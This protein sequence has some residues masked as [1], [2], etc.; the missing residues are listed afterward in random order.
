MSEEARAYFFPDAGNAFKDAKE[1]EAF[2]IEYD[3][4]I[5]ACYDELSSRTCPPKYS[6]PPRK[7]MARLETGGLFSFLIPK[8]KPEEPEPPVADLE[9]DERTKAIM[10]EFDTLMKKHGLSVKEILL[11]DFDR[12][13]VKMDKLTKAVFLL[14]L[15]HPEG[16]RYKELSDYQWE[17]EKIYSSITGRDDLDSIRKSVAD[18]CDPLNNSINEKVS[19]VKKAFRDAVDDRVARFYYIDGKKGTAKR[20]AL[21]RDFVLWG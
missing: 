8:Q 19:K 5:D 17:L 11:E 13:E 10:E 21:D 16:I 14:Y 6:A 4:K 20:I 9:L 3:S 18:L 1:D 15:K 7:R 12:K 2:L